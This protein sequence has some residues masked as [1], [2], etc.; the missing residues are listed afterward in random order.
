MSPHEP[1]D[2]VGALSVAEQWYRTTDV[3]E[4]IT[5]ISE[6]FVDP[7]L[8]ANMWLVHGS[9]NDLLV[10]C[11]LGVSPLHP[12]VTSLTRH[13]R[14]PIVVVTH[15]H[16]DHMGGA[17]E[18]SECWAHALEAVE[19]PEPG[20]LHG[21]TLAAELGLGEELPELLITAL[22]SGDYEPGRYRLRPAR[23]TRHLGD[24]DVVDLGDRTFE[25]LH[26]PGHTPGSIVLFDEHNGTLFSGDVLY[27]DALLDEIVGADVDDYVTSMR[28]LREL[29]VRRVRPGHCDSFD[30]S[31][32]HQLVDEYLLARD[33]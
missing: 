18:F 10:D 28:R 7:L 22:P 9:D 26:L 30:T 21:P 32:F 13:G 8:S 5:L 19:S 14:E 3:G 16:L 33:P 27:D 25:V 15:A 12:V 4:G 11:G 17:H 20:S 6:P 23:V 1:V 24:G 29:P 31:R 2:P